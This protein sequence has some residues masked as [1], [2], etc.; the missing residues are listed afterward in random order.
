MAVRAGW[1]CPGL[2]RSGDTDGLLLPDHRCRGL[3][4]LAR[5]CLAVP[6]PQ[7]DASSGSSSQASWERAGG[8]PTATPGKPACTWQQGVLV[9]PAPTHDL[10]GQLAWLKALRAVLELVFHVTVSLGN[11]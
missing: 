4:Q 2:V 8:P 10:H 11:V 6:S 5:M 7:G 3:R 9:R 1:L